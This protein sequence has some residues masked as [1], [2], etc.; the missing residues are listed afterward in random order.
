MEKE[1]D[2]LKVLSA[3]QEIP[4]PVGR[5]LLV[6]FLQGKENASI[7]RNKLSSKEHFGCLGY[8]TDELQAMVDNL[9]LNGM[10]HAQALQKNKFWKVLELTPKGVG[11]IVNPTLFKRK[12]S[13]SFRQKETHISEEDKRS[14]TQYL[15]FLAPYNDPQKKA[16][17]SKKK[18]ILCIAGAGSGKTTILTKRIDFLINHRFV[19]PG[20]I[21]AITFTRKARAEMMRRVSDKRV[22]I[23]TFNSFCEKILRRKESRIYEKSVRVV[24]YRD[25]I[26]IIEKSLSLLNIDP[27]V[28][29]TTY[30]SAAQQRGK[31]PEQL[32][33]IF[34]NDCFFIRDYFAFKH[35][36]LDESSLRADNSPAGAKMVFSVCNYIDAYMKKYGLRD[37][38]D[39][40]LDTIQFFEENKDSIP[41]FNHILIDEFQDVNAT[42]IKLA[43]LLNPPNIFCVGDPR[44]SIYGWR[45]SDIRYILKF[46]EKYPSCE[47]LTLT[48]NYRSTKPIVNLINKS[49]KR[50]GLP[51]LQSV[52]DGTQDIKLIKCNSEEKEFEFVIQKILA[53]DTPRSEI[54]VLARTNRQ[55]QELSN[56]MKQ[57]GILHIV[58]SHELYGNVTVQENNVTLATIHAIKGLEAEMVFV[59]GC[60]MNNFPCKG[61]EHPVIEMV[62][63]E[64]Y[65]KEEEERRLFYVAMS[66]AKKSLYLTYSTQ[67]TTYYITEKMKDMIEQIEAQGNAPVVSHNVSHGD[68]AT[69][70]K[71][72][73]WNLSRQL[74][75]PAYMI[76]TNRTVDE[77]MQKRPTTMTELENIHGLGTQKI[78]KYGPEILDIISD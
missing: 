19:D 62:K 38:A 46:E 31:T 34:M 1:F 78:M 9:I 51:D 28:A 18:Q 42:Q 58:R 44:Q 5:R 63:I 17:I 10:V 11:E 35:T 39:Q 74:S 49:I 60:T 64:E 7:K 36:K 30:F 27:G 61:S 40:L 57:R 66:R 73:R 41:K 48:K 76:I 29:I 4:F 68:M 71:T 32:S 21:L 26:K 3:L 14:F 69:K 23:E 56:V 72:W 77:I 6:S 43:D 53:S 45:G 24:T 67:K 52:K 20:K 2:Y 59:I 47:I 33:H 13:F 16:I 50:M 22:Q 70:L 75:I 37:F 15:E 55:L 8:E 65:D 25:K 54:F 12:L